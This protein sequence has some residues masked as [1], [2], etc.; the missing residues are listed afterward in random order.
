MAVRDGGSQLTDRPRLVSSL[1]VAISLVGLAGSPAPAP[2]GE[3]PAS[4]LDPPPV[5]AGAAAAPGEAKAL[6]VPDVIRAGARFVY[7]H[8]SLVVPDAPRPGAPATADGGVAQNDI[9]AVLP[10]R[11]LGRQTVYAHDARRDEYLV[12]SAAGATVNAADVADGRALWTLP[13]QLAEHPRGEGIEVTPGPFPLNGRDV[14]AVTVTFRT[15]TSTTTKAY[16][17]AT[18]LLLSQSVGG[19]PLRDP[20]VPNNGL[21]RQVQT[22]MRLEASRVLDLPWLKA[23]ATSPKWAADVRRMSY[24][25]SSRMQLGGGP[26]VAIP[27]RGSVTFTDRGDGWALG[28]VTT[29]VGDQPPAES[30]HA[31][32]PASLDAYWMN[33]AALEGLTPGVIDRDP[34]LGITVAYEVKDGPLGRLGVFTHASAR[35]TQTRTF[36]YS[37]RDGALV[38]F[39]TARR[40][41]GTVLEVQLTGR[42]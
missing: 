25:G 4:P 32:G 33:P 13:R 24:Q 12:M 3:S 2:A 15:P 9:V 35:G 14:Q 26:P 34:F 23:N 10:D 20:R 28:T 31:Q 41:T 30:A 38:Y 29:V 7:T 40:D 39:G 18:G 19:G 8:S 1:A 16:D 6:A 17:Q 36:G 5:R 11:V 42:E 27:V 22:S 37:L 21:N